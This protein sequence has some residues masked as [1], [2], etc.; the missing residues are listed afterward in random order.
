MTQPRQKK[1]FLNKKAR[2]DYEI[3]DSFEAGI[4][5]TGVEIKTIRSGRI[6]ITTSYVK[7]INGELL[8][9]GANIN[10]ES[11]NEDKQRTRKLLVH[12]S[13]IGKLI[14]KV[15][16]KGM[17][18]LPLKLYIAR[19]KAKL[20]VGVGRGLKNFDKREKLKNRDLERDIQHKFKNS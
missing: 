20:E 6:D 19:G 17:T 8:W 9:L 12:K 15:Q 10:S 1:E 5:L 2:H 16:E 14:G 4:A 3:S 11:G 7:I 18:L 13:E